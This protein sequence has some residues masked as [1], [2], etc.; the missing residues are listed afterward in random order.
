MLDC[1]EKSLL[2][3]NLRFMALCVW[4]AISW[5]STLYFIW[6]A[7]APRIGGQLSSPTAEPGEFPCLLFLCSVGGEGEIKK[8]EKTSMAALFELLVKSGRQ[9]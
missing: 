1:M 4:L 8:K 2:S 3:A 9:A 5:C 6:P 7:S